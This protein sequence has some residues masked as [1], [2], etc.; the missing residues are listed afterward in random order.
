MER[1]SYGNGYVV[2]SER[3]TNIVMLG[4][5]ELGVTELIVVVAAGFGDTVWVMLG[6]SSFWA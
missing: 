3:N 2:K 4:T 6:I 1:V 5:D